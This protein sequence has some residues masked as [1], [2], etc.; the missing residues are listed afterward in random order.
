MKNMYMHFDSRDH[1]LVLQ[2]NLVMHLLSNGAVT[3]PR[4]L[5]DSKGRVNNHD[6]RKMYE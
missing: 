3:D 2:T 6:S 5:H 4:P 1:A